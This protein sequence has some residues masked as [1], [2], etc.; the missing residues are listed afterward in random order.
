[1]RHSILIRSILATATLIIASALAAQ[2]APRPPQDQFPPDFVPSGKV[3]FK[4]YCAACH[5]L[6]AKGYGPARAAL[7]VPAAD[8]TTLAKRHGGEFPYDY[9]TN[10]L[11]FGP[12]VAAHGSSDMPTW[13]A[14]FQYM[15]NYNETSVQKRIKNL[16]TYIATLQEK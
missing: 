16:A 13:G 12:G 1:M 6:D 2:A 11:R 15:D 4:Q 8:L 14:L 5:G 7:K 10:I 9:V 3:M